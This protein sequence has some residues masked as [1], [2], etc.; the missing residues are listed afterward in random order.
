MQNNAQLIAPDFSIS[1]TNMRKNHYSDLKQ[2][3]STRMYTYFFK[4][5][6]FHASH[7]QSVDV[8]VVLVLLKSIWLMKAKKKDAEKVFDTFYIKA[9]TACQGPRYTT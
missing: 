5:V 9:T 2:R 8:A 3:N 6:C 7:H 4:T 1:R